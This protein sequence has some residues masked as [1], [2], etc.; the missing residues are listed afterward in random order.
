MVIE[1]A[2]FTVHKGMEED[3]E[4]T[5]S[6]AVEFISVT[7]GFINHQLTKS[8]ETKSKYVILVEWDSLE[9]HTE[10]FMKSE[11]FNEFVSMMD[12]FLDTV[13]MEHLEP[14]SGN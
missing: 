14:I 11:R 7:P 1:K 10:G 9:A 12:P 3:F 6:K 5:F 13:E 4:E 8:I 2:C